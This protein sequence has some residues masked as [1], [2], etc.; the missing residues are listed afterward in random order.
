MQV[1][2]VSKHANE[3]VKAFKKH[4]AIM[5]KMNVKFGGLFSRNIV[6]WTVLVPEKSIIE[7]N[8]ELYY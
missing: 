7:F 4:G 1:P 8:N 2:Y 6:S 3:I 5:Q